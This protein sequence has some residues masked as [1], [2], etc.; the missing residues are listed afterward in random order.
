MILETALALFFFYKLYLQCANLFQFYMVGYFFTQLITYGF[1]LEY[2]EPFL[3]NIASKLAMQY[4]IYKLYSRTA[5]SRVHLKTR[6]SIFKQIDDY[7]L[8]DLH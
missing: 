2:P 3:F 7:L 1:I 8:G 4:V 6:H 5:K